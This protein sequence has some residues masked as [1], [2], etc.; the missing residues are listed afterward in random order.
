MRWLDRLSVLALVVF[1]VGVAFLVVEIVA[2]LAGGGGIT[3]RVPVSA[4]DGSAPSGLTPVGLTPVDGATV[5]VRVAD[6]TAAQLGL[7]WLARLPVGL[8]GLAVV[9]YVAVLLR[10]ARRHDPFT[11]AMV[12]GLRGLAALTV[13]GGVLGTALA[14]VGELALAMN[15]TGDEAAAVLP[16]PVA[17]LLAGFGFQAVAEIV[18]RGVAMRDELAGVV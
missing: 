9:G 15:V 3:A 6:P 8:A 2:G 11:P 18:N 12:R 4:L 13:A 16:I 7:Y 5:E 14:A 1:G 17:W 10:R